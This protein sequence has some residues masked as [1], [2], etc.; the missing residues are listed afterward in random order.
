MDSTTITVGKMR[1]PWAP[2][3]GNRAGIKLHVAFYPEYGQPQQVIESIGSKHDGP[4]GEDRKSRLY[5]G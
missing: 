1:L 3:H 2:N 4:I 5:S